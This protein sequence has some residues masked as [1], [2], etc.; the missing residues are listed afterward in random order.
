MEELLRID[1]PY[2]WT[3]ECQHSFELLKRKLVKA[4]ILKFSDWSRNFHVHIDA[5]ALAISAILTQP[6]N[7]VIDHPMPRQVES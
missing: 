5:S 7:Y 6:T 1:V 3:E 4:C 2:H